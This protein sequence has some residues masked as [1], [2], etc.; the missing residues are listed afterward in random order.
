MIPNNEYT[1]SNEHSEQPEIKSSLPSRSE[2]H[3]K[4]KENK[5]EKQKEQS[6]N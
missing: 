4:K 5:Q 1:S 2:V 3:R 6:E